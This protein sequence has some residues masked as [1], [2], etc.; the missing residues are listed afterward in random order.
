VKRIVAALILLVS[1]YACMA[2]NIPVQVYTDSTI[3]R[4][5]KPGEYPEISKTV[6]I[7][8]SL[9]VPYLVVGIMTDWKGEDW[10]ACLALAMITF[11]VGGV[12]YALT[13]MEKYYEPY[14]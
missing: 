9:F 2:T 3:V 10:I 7:I 5:A 8:G 4:A 6:Y 11:G 12:V 13:R 14:K 1:S